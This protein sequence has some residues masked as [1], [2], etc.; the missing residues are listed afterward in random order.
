[1]SDASCKSGIVNSPVASV[2]LSDLSTVGKCLDDLR[3]MKVDDATAITDT[4]FFRV[5]STLLELCSRMYTGK[6]K[7]SSNLAQLD[8]NLVTAKKC[9]MDLETLHEEIERRLL[10]IVEHMKHSVEREA[11]PILVELAEKMGWSTGEMKVIILLQLEGT[12]VNG[13]PEWQK[14]NL[15]HRIRLFSGLQTQELLSF[16]SPD[17]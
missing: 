4:Q 5:Y 3:S 6:I 11:I 9:L 7:L 8:L 15:L 2:W 16:F 1:M 17:R 10:N 13:S 12:G 14:L